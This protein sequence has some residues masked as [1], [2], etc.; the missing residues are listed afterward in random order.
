ML[1]H[2]AHIDRHAPDEGEDHD[3]QLGGLLRRHRLD[4]PALDRHAVHLAELRQI[5]VGD[6]H[7]F[8][9]LL[10]QH[11]AP[12]VDKAA[13]GRQVMIQ[14]G[15]L[16]IGQRLAGILVHHHREVHRPGVKGR[17]LPVGLVDGA[18]GQR[19]MPGK[20]GGTDPPACIA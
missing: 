3:R 2:T 19:R 17:R 16:V 4:A 11:A 1:N 14:R 8:D 20:G 9:G 7:L 6:D 5:F 10:G 15:A 12:L 13:V 18:K